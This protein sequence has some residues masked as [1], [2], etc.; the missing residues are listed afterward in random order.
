MRRQLI[1]HTTAAA[2]FAAL[3]VV[4]TWP[5]L[6]NLD[7]AVSDPGDPSIVIWILD[8]SWYAAFHQPLSFFHANIFHPAKW[9]LAFS[10]N[11]VGIAVF[12]FPLRAFGVDAITAFNVAM[13]AG[14]AFS[15]F[16]A[17]V[18]GRHLTR[19]WWGGIG[20]GVFYAFLPFRFI[21]LPHL[22]H[23]W[24]GWLPLL[25]HA[26]LLYA[27]KPSR[28]RAAWFA[29]VFVINGLSNVHYLFFGSL[30]AGVTALLLLPKETW[31]RF[32]IATAIGGLVLAP[33]LYPYAAVAKEYGL[34]R[35]AGEVMHYS[36]TPKDWIVPASP[37]TD[38]ER[39]L[40]PG[41]IAFPLMLVAFFVDRNTLRAAATRRLALL[42]IVIGFLGS[43]GFHTQFHAFLYGAVPGFRAIRVPAR[44]A[45]IAYVGIAILVALVGAFLARRHRLLGALV[46]VLLIVAFWRA[47]LRWF[48]LDVE[49]PP[50][51]T[52]LA[53]Q[54]LRGAV[55]E[56][57]IGV[58]SDYDAMRHATKHHQRLVNGASGFVPPV[59]D[60]LRHLGAMTPIPDTFVD[61]LRELGIEL[62]VVHG[63][64][65]GERAPEIHQWLVRELDRDRL[66]YVGRFDTRLQGDWVFRIDPAIPRRRD[67]P[68]L[69][70]FLIGVPT[71][72]ER[73][74]MGALELTQKDPHF[75]GPAQFG[76]WVV[77]RTGVRSVDLWFDNGTV[78]VPARMRPDPS[79]NM[80][81]ILSQGVTR[82][83][84]E[85]AL[86]ARPSN[87]RRETDVYV[88][89]T[90]ESGK[91]ARFGSRWI[92]WDER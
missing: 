87:V 54:T 1:P 84:F 69:D 85:A 47:P 6:P 82:V 18:L 61:R 62:L 60:E 73:M 57:P 80:R 8:W 5:L 65:L 39:W 17:Y 4:M 72:A 32:F 7:R 59:L 14:Y 44:W 42:W 92:T 41:A 63:D 40:Y 90:D 64:Q 53:G 36:A 12:L 51:Y 81:C 74:I 22:Q 86:P 37:A 3:S 89:V 76:G 31:L 29:F 78:R 15:G 38:P 91:R 68:Y 50:V 33:F 2:L 19:S 45:V 71:C 10:E 79:L 25:L 20:A 67:P 83:R 49:T 48:L 55:A 13:L 58:D 30:A 56:L 66:G 35:G 34:Q 16:G 43:L 21:Q 9:T 46:P 11:L 75:R 77:S 27:E 23:I 70:G 24:G 52:W 28:K 88:E 26:V